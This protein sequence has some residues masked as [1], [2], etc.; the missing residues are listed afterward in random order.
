MSIKAKK[1]IASLCVASLF[2]GQVAAGVGVLRTP[3]VMSV[4]AGLGSTAAG[5][6]GTHAAPLNGT[7][8]T[9]LRIDLS[10]PSVSVPAAQNAKAAPS[11]EVWAGD[12][13]AEA[14]E[15][16]AVGPSAAR[17]GV[18]PRGGGAENTAFAPGRRSGVNAGPGKTLRNIVGALH[19][20]RHRN[21]RTDVF[22]ANFD[23]AGMHSDKVD[24]D[25]FRVPY[26]PKGRVDLSKTD[27]EKT[28]GFKKKAKKRGNK[29]NKDAVKSLKKDIGTLKEMQQRL[30]ASGEKA[31][32]LVFQAM[33]TGGKDGSIRYVLGPLNPQGVRVHSFKKPTQEEVDQ[34]YLW[35]IQKRV[36]KKGMVGVFNRS[37]FEDILVPTVEG[38]LSKRELDKRYEEIRNFEKYMADS[39]VVIMKF[40]LNISKEEQKR[41]LEARL[42]DPEKHWKFDPNDL[43]SR[44]KWDL[45][46]KAYGKVLARTSTEWAPWYIIPA[47][48]KW[49][50]NFLIGRIIRKTMEAMHL[51]FPDPPDGLENIVVPD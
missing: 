1:I 21:A 29:G 13:S 37:H 25:E 34:G 2:P 33:D 11:A 10:L 4:P 23:G 18:L 38:T 14:R 6:N 40:F 7:L 41:R 24:I 44:A 36:P 47:N 3:R 16:P 50:R 42:A 43:K 27:P 49:F 19:S 45:Y 8:L 22:T 31:V 28:S 48:H 39:G 17:K 9:G 26:S 32:L 12:V 5:V 46:M 15:V 51:T 20:D 30:Y 35:R